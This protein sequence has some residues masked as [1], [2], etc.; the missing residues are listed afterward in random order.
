MLIPALL[1]IPHFPPAIPAVSRFSRSRI[2]AGTLLSAVRWL[3][4]Q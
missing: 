1:D 2:D 3:A 4:N